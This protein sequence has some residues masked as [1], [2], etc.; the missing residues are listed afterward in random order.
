MCIKIRLSDM[1]YTAP[2]AFFPFFQRTNTSRGLSSFDKY[3]E[4][5][6]YI[7]QQYSEIS[8]QNSILYN[9]R[10]HKTHLEK[11]IVLVAP[12]TNFKE[13]LPQYTLED[14]NFLDFLMIG[15]TDGNGKVTTI[16]TGQFSGVPSLILCSDLYSLQELLQKKTH[17]HSIVMDVSD[18]NSFLRQLSAFDQILGYNLPITCITD[19]MNSFDLEAL[20]NRGFNTW[21]WHESNIPSEMYRSNGFTMDKK[22]ENHIK[23]N[24]VYK[25]VKGGEISK[26][27]ERIS[28]HKTASLSFNNKM[29]K[30]YDNL[31]SLTFNVLR[32]TTPLDAERVQKA[33]FVLDNCVQTLSDEESF[34]APEIKEDLLDAIFNLYA[35]YTEGY[36]LL[37][38]Q[39]LSDYLHNTENTSICLIVP[40]NSDCERI[41]NYWGS[42]YNY[43]SK[44]ITVKVMTPAEYYQLKPS[45][46]QATIVAGWLKRAVMRKILFSFNT[47]DYVVLLNEYEVGWKNYGI[48]KWN[49]QLK[50]DHNSSI[51]DIVS[52][53]QKIHPP[54]TRIPH[55][56]VDN[57]IS[58]D[59]DE[60]DEIE[61]I[62]RQNRYGKYVVSGTPIGISDTVEAIPVNFVGGFMAFYKTSHSVVSI[63]KIMTSDS[64]EIERLLPAELQVG[65]I[66]VIRNTNRDII[67]EL[68]DVILKETGKQHLRSISSKWREALDIEKAFT[69]PDEIIEKLKLS[70]CIRGEQTIKGWL[71]DDDMI[72]PQDK[73][74]LYH[75]ALATENEV[76]MEMIDEVHA[77]ALEVRG[78]HTAAGR[79]LSDQL[80]KKIVDTIAD[81][82]VVDPYNIW[83]P[84]DLYIDDI[85]EVR[86]LKIIDIGA[87]IIV[88]AANTNRLIEEQ[89]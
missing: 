86:I 53:N 60:L 84:I 27:I 78:A 14:L 15:Q 72:A 28:L 68:A 6:D 73:N 88:D 35:V 82:E 10:K 51:I 8:S 20:E 55:D 83:N 45:L 17:I 66:I 62:R 42:R 5:R 76:L 77:A 69:P 4:S 79:R 13:A 2:V 87:K 74:D 39:A 46:Y 58:P 44:P 52:I 37:K 67:R 23:N 38:Q 47:R 36:K 59:E 9:L 30:A 25:V 41:Q 19:I 7:E 63:T 56:Q 32:E 80:K 64:D 22:I 49:N 48:R 50:S 85:G 12:M 75:I 1:I 31:Y 54:Q 18:S 3:K 81:L 65:D 21:R 29:L 40:E 33:R 70:G 57:I 16:N 11:A 89:E 61:K 71:H 24:I 26:A 34:L 43:N